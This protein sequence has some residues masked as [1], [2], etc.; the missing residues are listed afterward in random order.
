MVIYELAL[1]VGTILALPL[2][3]LCDTDSMGTRALSQWRERCMRAGQGC[4]RASDRLARFHEVQY[5]LPIRPVDEFVRINRVSSVILTK[6]KVWVEG[7]MGG[8][9][10]QDYCRH[11]LHR[12][13][14]LN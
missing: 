2:W 1:V 11:V 14:W 9:C 12:L 6:A 10:E 4:A 8:N 5:L 3:A 13:G 7:C